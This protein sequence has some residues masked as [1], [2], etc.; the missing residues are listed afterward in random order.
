MKKKQNK[1]H[2]KSSGNAVL[3]AGAVVIAI[4]MTLGAGVLRLSDSGKD[5]MLKAVKPSYVIEDTMDLPP[6]PAM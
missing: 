1:K 4:A 6:E 2:K 5:E 3:R